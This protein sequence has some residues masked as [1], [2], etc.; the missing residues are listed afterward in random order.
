[1]HREILLWYL[2]KI[3]FKFMLNIAG[4]DNAILFI[5]LFNDILII[6]FYINQEFFF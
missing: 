3:I 4:D 1:M 5:Y 6:G 2:L